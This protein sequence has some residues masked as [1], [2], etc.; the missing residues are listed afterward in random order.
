[1]PKA[2]KLLF[3]LLEL[4]VEVS[5]RVIKK[6]LLEAHPMGALVCTEF[7]VR[8]YRNSLMNL[9]FCANV[10]QE[11]C[12]KISE[13]LEL[14]YRRNLRFY[15]LPFYWPTRY[16]LAILRKMRFPPKGLLPAF[17]PRSWVVPRGPL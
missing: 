15:T 2:L 16:I 8:K 7:Q 12:V 14:R 1:M 4:P 10:A 11:H 9:H 5:G 6:V 13:P 17:P 3:T